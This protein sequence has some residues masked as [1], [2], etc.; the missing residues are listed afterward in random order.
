MHQFPNDHHVKSQ[1]NDCCVYYSQVLVQRRWIVSEINGK[2]CVE[3]GD[4]VQLKNRFVLSETLIVG[5]AQW[6]SLAALYFLNCVHLS[7]IHHW[8]RQNFR[9]VRS[10]SVCIIHGKKVMH[11]VERVIIVMFII[12]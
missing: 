7:D 5:W 1:Q 2:A 9:D 4:E 6:N 11:V 10:V 12:K 8:K 3:I